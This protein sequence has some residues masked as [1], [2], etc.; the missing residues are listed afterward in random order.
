MKSYLVV[1]AGFVGSVVAR[2]L[3][4]AGHR[5]VV[6]DRRK[7]IGGNA[8][9]HENEHGERIHD[10]GP[11]L[12]H[13]SK[14][15]AA[16]AWLS[17]FTEWTQYEHRVRAK[18]DDQTVPLPVN[19]ETLELMFPH[20][21]RPMTESDCQTLLFILRGNNQYIQPKNTD[22]VFLK[23]VG[24]KLANIFFRPYTRKMWGKDA[25]EI[26]AAVGARIPVRTNRDDRYFTDD[27]QAMPKD[28][29]TAMFKRIL[30]H[31]N[32][33]V[34]LGIEFTK[35]A[36]EFFDH[37]FL[38]IPIDRYY[39]CCY[40]SLPYR[41]VKFVPSTVEEDQPATTVNFTDDGPYTRS[42]QWSLIP[43]SGHKSSG[44]HTVTLEVP[45]HPKHNNDECYYPVRNKDSLNLF[46]R[47]KE[48]AKAEGNLTFCGRLGWFQ[49]LD[50]VPAVTKALQTV[51]PFV[52]Q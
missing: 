8:Y 3:A 16:V 31:P 41:S 17:R 38:T 18:V 46:E 1:G 7:H 21:K 40:G 29:Y 52:D 24:E 14:N 22:E 15:S 51:K 4:E 49:Y 39:E 23:S 19:V 32:I 9:D 13:G 48:L 33:T 5:V 27:F 42:T 47:Y 44:P 12:F 50:M 10:Y 11:H 2:E 35:H 30:D 28:G 43:N 36:S 45:C 37:A 26:E 34:K 20:I 25:T 6:I